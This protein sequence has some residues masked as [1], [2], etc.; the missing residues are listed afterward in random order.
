MLRNIPFINFSSKI[1]GH[2]EIPSEYEEELLLHLLYTNLSREVILSFILI[3]ID[4]FLLVLEIISTK[5][6]S[7]N[8]HIFGY[9]SYMHIILII[10]PSIFLLVVYKR[11]TDIRL[12]I[13]LSKIM[14]WI[15]NS[16]VLIFCALIS[17]CNATIDRLPYPYIIAM[18]CIG[19][20]IIL[21]R[22]ERFSIYTVSYMIY[23][24]ACVMISSD[25]YHF[26]RNG[27]FSTLLF[28]LALIGSHM[29]FSSFVNDFIN[30]KIILDKNKELDKL[31]RATEEA[32]K[33]RTE[34][35]N[36]TVEYEKLRSSFFANIS[37]E[38][39]TPLTVIF[40]AEQMLGLI[41]KRE[42]SQSGNKDINQYMKVIR[43]NC[44]R[45]IRLVANLIDITKI[46]AGYFQVE[47]RNCDIIKVVEDI[48][49]SVAKFIEYREL[50]LIFDTEV[51]EL[52][53]ACDPDKIERIILNILSNA[54]KFTPKGGSI[55]VNICE[56]DD[57]IK[58]HIKDS[59]IGIPENMKHSIFER[60]IQVDKTISRNHEGSGIGLSLVKSLVDMHDGN[61]K[62]I[63]EE[64]K[65]SE[66]I[67]E[68]PKRIVEYEEIIRDNEFV[69]ENR[70]VEKINI[71][72]SDIYQ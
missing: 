20:T 57:M 10:I 54:V 62:L 24:I 48:T 13:K 35:L 6:W 59:G 46:D 1:K 42:N 14:H 33:K 66:F 11:R 45:L 50:S 19:S 30:R 55:Y 67:I 17:I 7:R 70:N 64:G 25:S 27:F 38:L 39:R 31:Y 32:L 16:S 3:I 51:E 5:L 47:L 43:Q 41:I 4:I 58:I 52:T 36:E 44:Y 72:F 21:G 71:E 26:I 18:F 9:F 49:L 63:S 56:R 15:I 61:I 37:H 34:E 68:L 8:V 23:L 22:K 65:G 69:S 12:N 40:S 28:I 2:K 60:F 53:I 29:H